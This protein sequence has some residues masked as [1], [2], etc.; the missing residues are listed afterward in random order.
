MTIKHFYECNKAQSGKTEGENWT[1]ALK[2]TS[3][4]NYDGH[5]DGCDRWR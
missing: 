4:C 3:N 5:Q 2:Q 1:A